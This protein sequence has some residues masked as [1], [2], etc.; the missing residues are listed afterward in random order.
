MHILLTQSDEINH[1]KGVYVFY[2]KTENQVSF[3]INWMTKC[4]FSYTE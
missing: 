4:A 2:S 3:R 1:G